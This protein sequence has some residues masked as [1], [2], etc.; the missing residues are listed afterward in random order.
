LFVG[1]KKSGP[2]SILLKTT[3]EET[4]LINKGN[5]VVGRFTGEDSKAYGFFLKV[6]KEEEEFTFAHS[7]MEGEETITLSTTENEVKKFSSDKMNKKNIKD[8]IQNEGYALVVELDQKLWQRSSGTK[9][10]ILAL[11]LDSKDLDTYKP[12]L[13]SIAESNKGKLITCWMD[14][15]KNQ[16]LVSSWGGSGTV[17]PTAFV[18]NYPTGTPK[19]SAWNEETEKEINEES[20]KAFVRD[21]LAGTYTSFKKIRTY[22]PKE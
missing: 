5:A 2:S 11:F 9:M 22:S 18:V 4:E 21:A 10:P 3:E 1:L 16:Q 14:G 15:V 13:K 17:L 8:W 12:M 7:F 6:A 19:I 20:L